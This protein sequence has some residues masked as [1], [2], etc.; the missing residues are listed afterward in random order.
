MEKNLSRRPPWLV[1]RVPANAEYGQVSCLIRQ[2]ELNTVCQSAHCPNLG[3]CFGNGTATFLIL[4]GICTRRCAFCVVPKGEPSNVDEGEAD[5][6]A[7]AVVALKLKHVVITSVTRDDLPDGGAGQFAACIGKVHQASPST[8]VEVLTPDFK[9]DHTALYSVLVARPTVFNHNIETVPS[10]YSVV[11]P[12]A[13][14]KRS[15][16]LLEAVARTSA[17][18]VKSGLM[19]GLGETPDEVASVFSDLA[20]VGVTGVTVGQYLRPSPEQL[21]VVD[22]IHPDQFR[23]YEQ[24]AYAA[25]LK[26]A[27]C[28]P[29]VRSSYHA[30]AM[31]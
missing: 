10:L 1:Q 4:G 16:R 31:V 7:Q 17:L 9:G 13:D 28:G 20:A 26:K 3:E 12:L 14:Y 22:Y 24:M 23:E 6:V 19:V 25:G 21:P 8:S 27:V 15:L 30:A 5:K 29:L 18:V 2:L 11:R